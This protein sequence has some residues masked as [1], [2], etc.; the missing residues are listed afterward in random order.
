MSTATGV[1]LLTD[2]ATAAAVDTLNMTCG[3]EAEIIQGRAKL[4]PCDALVSVMPFV[5][6][7][8][9]QLALGLPQDTAV[10]LVEQFAGF[11]IEFDSEDM[12]DVVGELVNVIAGELTSRLCDN[13]LHVQMGLPAV[14]RG[15]DLELPVR[16]GQQA[17]TVC[18]SA[19][20]GQF[21][22][23]VSRAE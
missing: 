21:W 6:D 16:A 2:T 4:T 18:L 5:G 17:T 19:P 9:W 7:T 10:A 15:N 22:I 1:D 13:G 23:E 8:N 11:P 20:V 12:A 14:V 3:W